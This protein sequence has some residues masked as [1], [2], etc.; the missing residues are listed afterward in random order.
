MVNRGLCIFFRKND[1]V[2]VFLYNYKPVLILSYGT[3][4]GGPPESPNMVP[5]GILVNSKCGC[6]HHY[7]LVSFSLYLFTV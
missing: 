2:P 3:G 4:G 7:W 1:K 6:L 5:Q